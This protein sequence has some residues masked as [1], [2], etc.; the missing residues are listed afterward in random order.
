MRSFVFALQFLT[1]F[2]VRGK[3]SPAPDELGRSMAY[4]PLVGAILG[5]LLVVSGELISGLLPED[6]TAALVLVIL[7][8][9]TGALHLDGFADTLDGI[10]GGRDPEERLRIMRD[11]RVGAVGAASVVLLLLVKYSALKGL[12]LSDDSAALFIAP[13][14]GR[15]SAVPMAWWARYAREGGGLGKAFAG[16]NLETMFTATVVAFVLTALAIGPSAVIFF[17]IL[18]GF[19]YVV[20]RFFISK[21]GGVTGDIFGFQIETA[22]TLFMILALIFYRA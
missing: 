19:V 18:A 10:A 12:I 9:S 15:W 2:S 4:F 20:T 16:L 17:L 1:V 14:L 21:T 7:V 3:A 13:V 11:C 6:I 5:L 8:V 22:E